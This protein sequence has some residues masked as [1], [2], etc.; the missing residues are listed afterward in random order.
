MVTDGVTDQLGGTSAKPIAFGYQ[1][2]LY[3]LSNA[4]HENASQIAQQLLQATTT[5][6]GTQTRRDDLTIL[7]FEV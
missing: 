7:V 4:S 5:W 6:Q 2:M 1:R 3:A